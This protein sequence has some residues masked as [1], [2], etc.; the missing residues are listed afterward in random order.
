[1]SG[2][3]GVTYGVLWTSICC[4]V[5]CQSKKEDS[6]SQVLPVGPTFQLSNAHVHAYTS[7]PACSY[8]LF[9]MLGNMV[10]DWLLR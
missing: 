9:A 1:M 5:V 7:S 10:Y 3:V 2:D 4:E 6:V 8:T